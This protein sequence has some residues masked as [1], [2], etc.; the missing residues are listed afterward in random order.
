MWIGVTLFVEEARKS[1]LK[2]QPPKKQHSTD[3]C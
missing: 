1:T 3:F 2:E